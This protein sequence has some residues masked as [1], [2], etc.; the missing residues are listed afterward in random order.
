[1]QEA[2]SKLEYLLEKPSLTAK[3]LKELVNFFSGL[4]DHLLIGSTGNDPGRGLLSFYWE[5]G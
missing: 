5:A 1:M 4:L 3:E 2:A